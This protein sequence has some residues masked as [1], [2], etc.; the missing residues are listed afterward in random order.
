MK[1]RILGWGEFVY[2]RMVGECNGASPMCEEA[3]KPRKYM[4]AD[5]TMLGC[6]SNTT[7]VVT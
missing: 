2:M 4:R 5:G 6:Y 3:K 7:R 1:Y